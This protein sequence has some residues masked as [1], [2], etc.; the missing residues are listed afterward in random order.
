MYEPAILFGIIVL[1]GTVFNR[2]ALLRRERLAT[3]A[4]G[5]LV[6]LIA[7]SFEGRPAISVPGFGTDAGAQYFAAWSHQIGELQ[8]MPPW[9]PTLYRWTGLGL[10]A[11][12]VLLLMNRGEERRTARAH[13]L[14]L[15]AVFALTCW[16]ARWGYFLPLVYAMSLPWQ[17]AAIGPRLRPAAAI[18]FLLGLLPMAAEWRADLQPTLEM[19]AALAEQ[20]DDTLALRDV[21][22]FIFHAGAHPRVGGAGIL[23]PW[24]LSPPLAYWSGQPALAG[25][26]HESLPGI[27]DVDRFFTSLNLPAAH[28]ILRRREVRWVVAYEP[29]RV[30]STAASLLGERLSRNVLGFVLYQQPEAKPGYLR[31]ALV[32]PYF[33]VYEVV[34]DALPP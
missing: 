29:D 15:A 13:M 33:K 26:S 32:N 28:Q 31:L 30:L 22:R 20:R 11:A 14:L 9:S 34:T 6:L 19:R 1:A 4:A 10:V 5:G 18:A 7:L 2:G 16:Q 12:P 24:W 25:S 17:C 8:N 3:L 27:V 23:A 21:A